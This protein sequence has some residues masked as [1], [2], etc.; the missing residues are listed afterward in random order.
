VGSSDATNVLNEPVL[1]GD[2]GGEEQRVQSR[3]M[4]PSPLRDAKTAT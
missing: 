3:A 4:N 1:E 2:R